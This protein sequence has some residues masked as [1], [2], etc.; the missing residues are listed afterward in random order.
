MTT[1]LHTK[2]II[3]DNY[4]EIPPMLAFIGIDTDEGGYNKELV[5]HDGK[6]ISLDTNE[7]LSISVDNPSAIYQVGKGKGKFEWI[8]PSNVNSLTVLS[9]GAGQIRS[10]GRFA[11]TYEEKSVKA[12]LAF[13]RNQ[14][15]NIQLVNNPKYKLLDTDIDVHII[16]SMAGGTGG[17]T[18]INLAY[19]VQ[20]SLPGCRISGY[21]VM[22]GV[23]DAMLNGAAVARV[24]SNSYGSIMDLDYL[25]SLSPSSTPIT[26]ELFDTNLNTTERPF[27]A[28]YLIDNVDKNGNTYEK[29]DQISEMISLALVTSIGKLGNATKSVADN[30]EQHITAGNMDMEGKRAWVSSLGVGEIIYSGESL[31]QIY[32][33]EARKQLTE[34]IT[35]GGEEENTTKTA[36]NWI[37]ANVIRENHNKDDV[38]DYFDNIIGNLPFYDIEDTNRPEPECE[39]YISD[40]QEEEEGLNNK[41]QKLKDR[42]STS[43]DKLVQ[44]KIKERGGVSRCENILTALNSEFSLCNT[45]MK[46]ETE[47]YKKKKEALDDALKVSQESLK[48]CIL[49]KKNKKVSVLEDTMAVAI[50]QREITRREMA[51]KFYDWIISEVDTYIKQ[52]ETLRVNLKTVSA[53]SIKNV[54]AI[55]RK[56]GNNPI[57]FQHDL[58]IY[59]V[60]S[61]NCPSKDIVF[62]D[63]VVM[64]DKKGGLW[65]FATGTSQYVA[66]CLWE[67]TSTMSK[68]QEY[69]KKTVN[70]VLNTLDAGKLKSVC[71]TVIAKAQTLLRTDTRGYQATSNPDNS[72]YVGV[73][74]KALSVL[75]KNNLFK[76]NVPDPQANVNIVS[77]GLKDRVIIFHQFGVLPAFAVKPLDGFLNDYEKNET[78]HPGTSHWDYG[79]YQRFKEEDFD[80]MPKSQTNKASILAA[81]VQALLFGIITKDNKGRFFIESKALGGRPIEQFKVL[82]ANDRIGAYAYFAKKMPVI[83]NEIVNTITSLGKKDRT[84]PGKLKTAAQQEIAAGVYHLPGHLSLN[85]IDFTIEDNKNIYAAE[86]DL[87]DDEIGYIG[88]PSFMN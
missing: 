75:G 25:M 38:I 47:E 14:I 30:I 2:R 84:R 61:I 28:I 48:G 81:W 82:M 4:G 71:D 50:C 16:F 15:T 65:T 67:F 26:I 33:N 24:L 31:A 80:I 59:E 10:N 5:A 11:I 44:G 39:Q 63:F 56:I 55:R 78:A 32:A 43:L 76:T 72:Y 27:N 17:G 21:A 87:L 6:R 88:S 85:D 3:Y 52:I 42:I 41:L 86:Y 29:V 1:L 35:S 51:Q 74:D 8:A 58:A 66:N 13:M 57:I 22:G 20:Q 54:Q 18:F 7:R 49:F 34:M 19:L 64:M 37:D 77:I 36:N 40:A 68:A 12:K 73:E 46:D 70:D 23:F 45:E 69:C 60:D 62:N 83:K 53:D 9:R 79:L